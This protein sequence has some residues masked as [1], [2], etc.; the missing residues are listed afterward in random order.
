CGTLPT[1]QLFQAHPVDYTPACLLLEN[2]VNN[3]RQSAA[4]ANIDMEREFGARVREVRT[5][6][7]LS[8]DELAERSGV[9]RAALSKIERGERNTSLANA[10]RIAEAFDLPLAHLLDAR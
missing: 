1:G 2:F 7:H 6:Q 8:L 3:R 9:S 4:M 5:Q 10:V